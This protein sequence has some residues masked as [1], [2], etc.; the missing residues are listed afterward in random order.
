MNKPSFVGQARRE[1]LWPG[2]NEGQDAVDDNDADAESA[3]GHAE[4][5]GKYHH[6]GM[7]PVDGGERVH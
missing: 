5:A 3:R 2:E 6:R 7:R 1:A 4:S